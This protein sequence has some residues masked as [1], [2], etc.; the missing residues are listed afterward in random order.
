MNGSSSIWK[1]APG[2]GCLMTNIYFIIEKFTF[3]HQNPFEIIVIELDRIDRRTRFAA[4]IDLAVVDFY[5]IKIVRKDHPVILQTTDIF[6]VKN[7]IVVVSLMLQVDDNIG[8]I[9]LVQ[10]RLKIKI[11]N[12]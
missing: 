11:G 5:N 7:K 2:S 3:T 8:F 4:W 12:K 1:A 9:L 10:H 6:I